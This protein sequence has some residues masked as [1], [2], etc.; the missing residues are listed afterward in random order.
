MKVI[1]GGAY[2]GKLAYAK[3]HF[4]IKQYFTCDEQNP[5]IDFSAEA[6]DRLENFTL[7]CVRAGVEAADYFDQHWEQLEGKILICADISQGIVP[8]D[9][10]L[11]AW[12]EMNGRA[13]IYLCRRAEQVIR[14]FLRIRTA[15]KIRRSMKSQIHLIRHGITEGNQRRLYY[16]GADIPLAEEGVEELKRLVDEGIYPKAEEAA[17][18]TSGM[19]RT[20]QTFALI[21]GDEEHDQIPE[22]QEMRFGEFE[23]K[24][25]EELKEL[26]E[27]IQWIED[28][29]GNMESPGG[30]SKMGFAGRISRGFEILQEK[31]KKRAESMKANEAGVMPVS[32]AV[33]HGGVISVIMMENFPEEKRRF[34][35]WIPDP[36]HGYVLLIE[37][38]V[39]TGYES[40]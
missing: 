12:R 5:E 16:G 7:A 34:F 36:G 3:E 14:I 23:M 19:V 32:V 33:C 40:F 39:L 22:L 31:H 17:Y 28:K 20:E 9:P 15:V 21:F 38:D 6:V 29:S 30:E 18:Y 25:H 37:D 13:L 35:E 10:E 24:S 2:Q 1:F 26:P 4:G 8:M 11:R 27:Y